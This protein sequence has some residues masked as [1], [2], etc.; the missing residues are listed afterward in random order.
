MFITALFIIAKDG[1]NQNTHQLMNVGCPR[2]IILF[3]NI[4]L[5]EILIYATTWI[6]L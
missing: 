3:G 2:A 4:I 1:N 5:F 6:N